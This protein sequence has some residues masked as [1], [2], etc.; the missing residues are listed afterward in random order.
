MLTIVGAL[1]LVRPLEAGAQG[2]RRTDREPRPTIYRSADGWRV[3]LTP[4]IED[5]LDRYNR[6]FEMWKPRDYGD[7]GT[8]SARDGDDRF[9]RHGEDAYSSRQTPWAVIGDFNGDGRVDIALSGRTDEDVLV[10]LVLSNG[11]RTYRVI[12][13][14]AEPYDPDDRR[15]IRPATLR[16]V[17]PG[18]YVI[19]DPRLRR[20]REIVV[21]QP[22]V[23]ISGGRRQG[24]VLYVVEDNKAMPYY[25][26]DKPAPPRP[27]NAPRDSDDTH[28]KEHRQSK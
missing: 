24:A 7:G 4:A 23:Q 27:R 25:L 1:W 5:A 17:Y 26:S 18:R 8:R 21:E 6:D 28:D 11:Q 22:A 9:D 12:E 14:D 2:R 19:D 20:P 16:Y 3:D 15:S 13:L 10:V